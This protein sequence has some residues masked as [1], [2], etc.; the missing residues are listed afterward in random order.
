MPSQV[1]E[2]SNFGKKNCGFSLHDQNPTK[3]LRFGV[4]IKIPKLYNVFPA[5]HSDP[6]NHSAPLN[7]CK[8][9]P[10]KCFEVSISDAPS[11]PSS[12]P[13]NLPPLPPPAS[14]ANYPLSS[15]KP[16]FRLTFMKP[17]RVPSSN[18]KPSESLNLYLKIVTKINKTSQT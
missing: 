11:T 3:Q 17:N 15:A 7:P 12:A 10:T 5:N 2:Y 6:A 9:P 14:N 18:L 13:L 8:T 16:R 4:M 1:P